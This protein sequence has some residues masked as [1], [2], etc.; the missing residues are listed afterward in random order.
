MQGVPD[1]IEAAKKIIRHTPF[2][3]ELAYSTERGL[4]AIDA[5]AL[6]S[7]EDEVV[8]PYTGENVEVMTTNKLED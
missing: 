6:A 2:K 7:I 8:D 4:W 5:D 1:A 3:L